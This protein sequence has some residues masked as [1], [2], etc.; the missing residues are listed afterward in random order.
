MMS[1]FITFIRFFFS[2]KVKKKG[3]KTKQKKVKCGK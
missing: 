1:I 3:I 2:F